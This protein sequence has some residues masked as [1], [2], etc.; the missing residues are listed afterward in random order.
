[1]AIDTP[2]WVRDAI[3]YQI[4]PDRFARSERLTPPGP[5]EPWDAPPTRHGFK[6]GDLYGIAEHLDYLVDLGITALYLNPIFSSASNHRYHTVDYFQ[7]D[8]L[9]GADAAFDELLQGAHDHGIRV[10]LDAVFNHSGRGFWPFHHVLEAGAQSPYR[11]WFYLDERVLAGAASVRAYPSAAEVEALAGAREGEAGRTPGA[12]SRAVLGYEAW[13]DLPALPKLNIGHSSMREHLMRAAEHWTRRG[14]DGWRLDVPE[15]I[16]DV[17]FWREFRQRVRA[18]NPEAYIVGEIW[19]LAP[20]WLRGDRFDALMNYPLAEAI[21]GFAGAGRLDRDLIARHGTYAATVEPLDGPGFARRLEELSAAYE[22]DIAAVQ[23]NLLG[24][25]DLPRFV[26]MCSG[27][28]DSL[29]LATLIQMTLPGAPCVYYGDEIGLEGGMEPASRVAFPW[30]PERWDGDLR[31][32]IRGAIAL[33]HA[34]PVLR[35]GTVRVLGAEGGA[36]AYARSSA[37]DWI[38]VA[39]N[40]GDDAVTLR[41]AAPEMAGRR[42]QALPVVPS[43]E[44]R[45]TVADSNGDVEIHL[46]RR[47][48]RVFRAEPAPSGTPVS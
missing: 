36:V 25:H 37:S 33:R 26:T 20:E 3:F 34:F 46:A 30:E 9:L 38:L 32:D 40:A 5:F 4:F 31:D 13:W 23:L 8:P 28:R 14:I 35:H 15:E 41:I 2:G 48:G 44:P 10:V 12:A 18:I 22:P 27:D 43:D 45:S 42:L 11:E 39:V 24:S 29:R 1:V 21:L 16:T 47:T 19:H 6:G 17:D 7:V